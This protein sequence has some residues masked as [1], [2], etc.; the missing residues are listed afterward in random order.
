MDSFCLYTFTLLNAPFKQLYVWWGMPAIP[1]L[2]W[3]RQDNSN[4]H[5]YV[6]FPDAPSNP[7][8][9]WLAFDLCPC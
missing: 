2:S 9:R 8:E 5:I 3:L 4:K 7:R 1:A 6:V